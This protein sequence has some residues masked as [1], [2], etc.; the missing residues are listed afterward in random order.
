RTMLP[1][2]AVKAGLV[3]GCGFDWASRWMRQ[4]DA[5][6]VVGIDQSRNM[7]E[8]A[9]CDT[10]DYGIEYRIA[11]IETHDLPPDSLDLAY[12]ALTFHYIR[13][14]DRLLKT[15]ATTLRPSSHLVFTIEHPIYMTA[16]HPHWQLD[17]DG[18]KTWPV[19]GYA[20]EGE[21][22]TDWFAKGVVKYHRRIATTVNALIVAGFAIRRLEEF[23]PSAE[24]IAE[25]P[26]LLEELERPMMLL[27]SAQLQRE[28]SLA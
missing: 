27:V 18:R 19:N 17:E 21:R 24:Q 13:D 15:I 5:F 28:A 1:P 9:V 8:R 14:F 10:A 11:D 16:S 23:A 3:L 20:T 7:I 6:S 4:Q 22:R 2:F 25:T 12:R 26:A